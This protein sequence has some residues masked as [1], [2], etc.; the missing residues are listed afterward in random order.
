MSLSKD[1]PH[2]LFATNLR[3]IRR[4]TGLSIKAFGEK[5]GIAATSVGQWERGQTFPTMAAFGRLCDALGVEPC[6]LFVRTGVHV[7]DLDSLKKKYH[8]V[9]DLPPELYTLISKI[10]R[11]ATDI[12]WT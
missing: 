8:S 7:I 1:V 4:D 11:F 9:D 12:G 6:E 10:F 2:A 3:R 5:H